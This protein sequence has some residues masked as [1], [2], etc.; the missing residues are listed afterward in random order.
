MVRGAIFP[1]LVTKY[2]DF[3]AIPLTAIY[4]D[5]STT[6]IWPEIWKN[7]LITNIPKTRLPT[8]IG[9]LRKIS[10]AILVSKVYESFVLD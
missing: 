8:E 6:A 9:Q 1:A 5:I 4:N 3:L 10:C 2:A 7:E